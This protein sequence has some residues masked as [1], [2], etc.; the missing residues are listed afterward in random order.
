MVGGGAVVLLVAAFLVLQAW[1]L[2]PHPADEGIYFSGALQFAQGRIPYR[3]FFFA[4]PP[5]HLVP[6]AAL[7][8]VFGYA[9]PL[10]K[11]GTVLGGAVQGVAAYLIVT[12]LARRGAGRPA[13]GAAHVA[14]VLA[15]CSILFAE[16]LLKAAANDTGISQASGWLALACLL[17]TWGRPALAGTLAG[18]AAMTLLQAMPVVVTLAAGAAWIGGRRTGLRF[19]A[20]TAAVLA[21]V[22]VAFVALAGRAFFDQMYLFHLN[23]LD[24]PG[25]GARQ[26]GFVLADN[27]T[28]F[29]GAAAGAIALTAAGKSTRR[30][31]IVAL[32]A[33]IAQM[34]VMATRPRVFPFYFLPALFPAALLLGGGAFV[35]GRALLARPLL[36]G[37][38]GPSRR[39]VGVI[40][41]AALLV[42]TVLR[43]P[44]IGVVSPTRASQ[45]ERYTQSYRWVDAPGIGPLNAIVRAAL[46]RD[47][48][49]RA[50]DAPSAATQYLWQRTRWLDTLPTMVE[51]VR[52][53]ASQHPGTTLFGDSSVAPLVAAEAGVPI[54]AG[55]VDTNVERVRTGSLHLD[56]V[57]ALLDTSPG[58]LVLVGP[59]DGI[60]GY[61][62]LRERLTSRYEAIAT[63]TTGTGQRHTLWAR[64]R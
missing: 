51:H 54:A 47:G 43:W 50:G 2:L 45:R 58:T 11:A 29:V 23:K 46:W 13:Q 60:G 48:Q 41:G 19:V 27:W 40:A 38:S 9:L 24:R 8:A 52:R 20:G 17:L 57:A 42:L 53:W 63:F 35:A 26:L 18:V 56:E 5:L 64:T 25:E 28:L 34:L 10:A 1:S 16:T 36:A 6:N 21:V 3:D 32:A 30:L 37:G 22:H 62:A 15:C 12:G 14:G 39:A 44:L 49:R 55:L 59:A 7:F 31:A 61:P 4:H 33:A